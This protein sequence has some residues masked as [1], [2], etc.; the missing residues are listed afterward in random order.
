MHKRGSLHVGMRLEQGF[1]LLAVLI[2]H[3]LGGKATFED[4]M[5]HADPKVA[6]ISD[7][8][9]ILLSGKDR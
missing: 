7:V 3:A 4:Y 6:T 1:A 9:N 2:N 8:M 5:P